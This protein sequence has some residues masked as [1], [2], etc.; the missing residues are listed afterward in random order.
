[1]LGKNKFFWQK[2]ASPLET[3]FLAMRVKH[4]KVPYIYKEYE[5]VIKL[6]RK[7][8]HGVKICTKYPKSHDFLV[9]YLHFWD[10]LL[11]CDVFCI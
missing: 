10:I 5:K 2:F 7:E 3:I 4:K 8:S 9:K 11:F 6:L 1:M